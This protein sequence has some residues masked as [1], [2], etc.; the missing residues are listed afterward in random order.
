MKYA[1]EVTDE[2]QIELDLPPNTIAGL[3]A[4]QL[5][6]EVTEHEFRAALDQLGGAREFQLN[7]MRAQQ[8]RW[9]VPVTRDGERVGRAMICVAL[10]EREYPV[11]AEAMDRG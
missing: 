2:F 3:T 4:V 1:V 8:F 11:V 9:G 10:P 6:F 7:P 5:N